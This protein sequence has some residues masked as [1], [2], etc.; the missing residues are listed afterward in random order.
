MELIVC[1]Q[2]FKPF[3]CFPLGPTRGKRTGITPHITT[4]WYQRQLRK[5]VTGHQVE[6][7]GRRL[8]DEVMPATRGTNPIVSKLTNDRER[9]GRSS[10]RCEN[11]FRINENIWKMHFDNKWNRTLKLL[12]E[13]IKT[14]REVEKAKLQRQRWGIEDQDV[15]DTHWGKIKDEEK[16]KEGRLRKTKTGRKLGKI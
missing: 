16:G 1:S 12:K 8:Q 15:K 3:C 5:A 7:Y 10:G 6:S 14:L 9:G 4:I 11:A 13:G 2:C